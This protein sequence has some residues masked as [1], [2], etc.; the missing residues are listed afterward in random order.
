[1][2]GL[3]RCCQV[4]PVD[5]AGDS[6]AECWGRSGVATAPKIFV[7]A[8]SAPDLPPFTTVDV[9]SSAVFCASC[10]RLWVPDK[11]GLCPVCRWVA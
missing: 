2:T 10:N 4:N 5:N 11:D 9:L 3:C 7:T 6:C 8:M 1:M